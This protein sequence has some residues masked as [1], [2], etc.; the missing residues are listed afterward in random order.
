L[1]LFFDCFFILAGPEGVPAKKLQTKDSILIRKAIAMYYNPKVYE[2]TASLYFEPPRLS[3]NFRY[4]SRI[5]LGP[6]FVSITL[7]NGKQG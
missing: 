3:L 1:S 6:P 2:I 7:R 4:L 5:P